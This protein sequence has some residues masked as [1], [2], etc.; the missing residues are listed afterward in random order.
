MLDLLAAIVL[1]VL[2]LPL[3]AVTAVLVGVRLGRPIL[4]L[5]P[6]PGLHGKVFRIVKFRTMSTAEGAV[7][8]STDAARLSPLGSRLRRLSLDELPTLFNVI[9]GDMSF[10]GPRPLMVDYLPRYNAT[11]ARRHDV[12]PGITGLAQVNGRN[13]ISWREKFALDV[14]YVDTRGFALDARILVAT[15][16]T[17]LRRDGISAEGQATTEEFMGHG[18]EDD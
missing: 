2:A 14:L 11:E 18:D 15:V 3:M 17:V 1:T 5:Q 16:T 8:I 4:F 7:D 10:V 12:R 9:K 13:A 6:R